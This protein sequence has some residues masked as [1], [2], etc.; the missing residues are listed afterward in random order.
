MSGIGGSTVHAAP[1]Q[2]IATSKAV[3]LFSVHIISGVSVGV[4]SLKSGGASGTIY[5]KETGT[6]STGKTIVYE[7]NGILFPE[8][9]YLAEDTAPTSTTLSYV[10]EQ[11]TGTV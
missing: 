1:A 7:P 4:V 11:G 2:V 10:V 6:A 5:V 3:R 8:G 9:L